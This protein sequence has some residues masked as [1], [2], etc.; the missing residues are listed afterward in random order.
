LVYALDFFTAMCYNMAMRTDILERKGEILQWIEEERSKRFM[1]EQVHCKPETLNGWLRKMEIVYSGNKGSRG[2]ARPLQRKTFYEYVSD[3]SPETY[4]AKKKLI[5]DGIKDHVCE[6]C[7]L[8]EWL[9]EPIPIELHHVDGNRFNFDLENLRILC[10]NCHAKE[11]NNSGASNKK[12]RVKKPRVLKKKK[13]Y[14]CITCGAEVSLKNGECVS[15]AY[16]KREKADWPDAAALKKL[17]WDVPMTLI[18]KNLGVSG[19]AVAKRCSKLGIKTPGR[20][21]WTK[22]AREE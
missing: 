3:G 13:R 10:P 19:K 14:C 6:K 4:K 17:V 2:F 1:C 15:C 18:A 21:Y 5:E 12:V 16:K 11:P 20:G 8:S 7:G 22:P 9:G